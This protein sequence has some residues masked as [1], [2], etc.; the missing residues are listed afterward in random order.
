MYPNKLTA[1]VRAVD[2]TTW[3]LACFGLEA[4]RLLLIE[5]GVSALSVAC[6]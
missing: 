1:F 2:E 3:R 4:I 6:L 5:V